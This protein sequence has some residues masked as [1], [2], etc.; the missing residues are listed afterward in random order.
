MLRPARASANALTWALAAVLGIPCAADARAPARPAPPASSAPAEA[1]IRFR[2]EDSRIVE[3]ERA[4][5][6]LTVLLD[7]ARAL[8]TVQARLGFDAARLRLVDVRLRTGG[9]LEWRP[10]AAGA[11]RIALLLSSEVVADSLP[12]LEFEF[13]AIGRWGEAATVTV[14]IE[15]VAAFDATLLPFEQP[16]PALLTIAPPP[17]RITAPPAALSPA[18][19]AGV[20]RIEQTDAVGA[21]AIGAMLLRIHAA[22]PD[23]VQILDVTPAGAGANVVANL[24]T[25]REDGFV[26]AAYLRPSAAGAATALLDLHIRTT[27]LP[28]DS[29]RLDLELLELSDAD[30]A[31]DLLPFVEPAAPIWLHVRG[32]VWGA[33]LRQW[34]AGGAQYRVTAADA[35]VC[36][37]HIVG[38]P[39]AGADLLACDVHPDGPGDSYTGEINALDALVI[40][41]AVTGRDVSRFRVGQPR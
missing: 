24:E 7:P 33:P 35:L 36:L 37:R 1:P 16:A 15:Q 9:A 18:P 20:L 19:A 6:S 5:L 4:T 14:S 8:G 41:A 26:T 25:Q 34:E 12:L 22:D 31:R 28:G 3:A 27:A 10:A 23:L 2:M 40:L 21:P 17:L 32:A 29:I 39:T 38:S 11:A 30:G 13:E